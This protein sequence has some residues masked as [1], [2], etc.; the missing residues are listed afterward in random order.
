M[1]HH[2]AFYRGLHGLL[3]LKQPSVPDI[4]HNS[5]NSTCDP[6]KCTMG[7]PILTV[8]ICSGKSIKYKGLIVSS[9]F[10]TIVVRSSGDTEDGLNQNS[11]DSDQ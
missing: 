11:A 8:R 9:A 10:M 1:Q 3:R 7:S 6:L 5:E 4:H 2:A